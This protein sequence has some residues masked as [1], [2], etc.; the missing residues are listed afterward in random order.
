MF[1]L[2]KGMGWEQTSILPTP[3]LPTTKFLFPYTGLLKISINVWIL[4]YDIP[5]FDILIETSS[6]S[7]PV[8]F[9]LPE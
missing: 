6:V 7:D 5:V 3:M 8:S 1:L 4:L 9:L 2:K